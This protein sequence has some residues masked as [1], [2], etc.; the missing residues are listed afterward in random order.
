MSAA[1]SPLCVIVSEATKLTITASG[2][3]VHIVSCCQRFMPLF[4]QQMG[5][6]RRLQEVLL[7]YNDEQCKYRGRCERRI[8][9]FLELSQN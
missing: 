6:A 3:D 4:F 9:D 2:V 5:L 1:K 7:R 8:R